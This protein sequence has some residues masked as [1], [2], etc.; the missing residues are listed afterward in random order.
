MWNIGVVTFHT[1]FSYK[2]FKLGAGIFDE[3]CDASSGYSLDS[4]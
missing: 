4:Y 1:E 2:L 3:T